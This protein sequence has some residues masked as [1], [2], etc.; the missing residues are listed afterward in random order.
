MTTLGVFAPALNDRPW[1][2]LGPDD[3]ELNRFNG[4]PSAGLIATEFGALLFWQFSGHGSGIG[5]WLYVPITDAEAEHII[6]HPDEPLLEGLSDLLKGRQGILALSREGRIW[7]R[8]PYTFRA[9]TKRRPLLV[10]MLQAL[11]SGLNQS[12]PELPSGRSVE[13]AAGS[14]DLKEDATNL[15]KAT[16]AGCGV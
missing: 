6:D 2:P 16:L 1:L 4:R 3:V 14:N 12:E 10:Q 11:V 13:I 8:G 5:M 7:A 15:A 9:P